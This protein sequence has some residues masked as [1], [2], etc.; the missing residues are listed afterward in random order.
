MGPIPSRPRSRSQQLAV[1]AGERIE[2]Q[3][4]R[5]PPE[6]SAGRL[7]PGLS[8]PGAMNRFWMR[9]LPSSSCFPSRETSRRRFLGAG[10][11]IL[12][13]PS[14]WSE[15]PVPRLRG[16]CRCRHSDGR[17]GHDARCS[18]TGGSSRGGETPSR[19]RPA[20]VHLLHRDVRC[21]LLE[22]LL[23]S[24]DWAGAF[25]PGGRDHGRRGRLRWFRRCSG[26][27]R[28]NRSPRGVHPAPRS[29]R[30]PPG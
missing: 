23:A 30:T 15:T 21:V 18:S 4:D 28:R 27:P 6:R 3:P 7:R 22:P 9:I 10:R 26:P 13:P 11:A 8:E 2:L 1:P 19:S 14:A 12:E 24:S 29:L 5:E 17:L 25:K 16:T 20:A